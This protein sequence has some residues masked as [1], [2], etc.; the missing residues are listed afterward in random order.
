MRDFQEKR[1][2]QFNDAKAKE[3]SSWPKNK[4][5]ELKNPIKKR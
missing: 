5:V 1:K 2:K 3:K 4:K